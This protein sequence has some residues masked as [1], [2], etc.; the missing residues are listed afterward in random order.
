V[1]DLLLRGNSYSDTACPLDDHLIESD[2]FRFGDL[3]GIVDTG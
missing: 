1:V 3:F 2:P